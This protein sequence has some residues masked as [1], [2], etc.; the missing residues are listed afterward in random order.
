VLASAAAAA[1][2]CYWPAHRATR[3]DPMEVLRAE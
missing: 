3:V 1:L 2:A